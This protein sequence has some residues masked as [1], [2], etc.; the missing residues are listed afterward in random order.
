MIAQGEIWWADLAEPAGSSAG[1]RRPVLIV[2]GDALNAS[3]L[4][5]VLCVPLTSNVKW[6]DAPGNVLLRA[7]E[8][9]L[10]RDSVAN[11]SLLVAVDKA[12]LD[13]RVGKASRPMLERVLAGIDIVLGR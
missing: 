6:A 13:E 2:Q 12:Q 5:T 10:D 9:G 4:A 3:R 1:H 11:V 7:G 8:T